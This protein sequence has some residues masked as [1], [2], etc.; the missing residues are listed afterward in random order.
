MTVQLERPTTDVHDVEEVDEYADVMAMFH[1]LC[2]A[3][4]LGRRREAIFNR[5]LPL[6]DRIARHYG[7]RGEDIEDLVQVAR[8]GLVKA[9]N[10]FDPT[11]GSHFVAF[12]VPTMMGEVRRHFRDHGWS[13]HVP[14]RLKD[15]HGHITRATMELTQTLGRAPT[16]GQL[17]EMLDMRREDIVDSLLAAEA[18]RVHSIDAPISSG[19]SAPRM[20]SDTVGE[21]DF[22][23]DRIT[24]Q[25]TVRPLLAALPERER[26]VL[27]L[28]FFESMTQ[29]QIAERIG[30]S[31]M[32]VSRILEKTLRELRNQI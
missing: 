21:I 17:A 19:D 5:C 4:D 11:K 24:D 18:Y 31:Q 6:A 9:V 28:R 8:L 13:M 29:S 14:R 7:G 25:E 22:E 12:A 23:F 2:D 20:V 15:R 27:Y 32:H 1:T 3:A 30:V 26:T 10:R 16:A